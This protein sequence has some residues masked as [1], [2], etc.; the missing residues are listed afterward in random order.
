[1]C[2]MLGWFEAEAALASC[3][4]RRLRS[5][6]A[7]LSGESVLARR[8]GPGE[9]PVPSTPHPCRPRR[10]FRRSDTALEPCRPSR[11]QAIEEYSF[12]AWGSTVMRRPRRPEAGAGGTLADDLADLAHG[13]DLLGQPGVLVPVLPPD[14]AARLVGSLLIGAMAAALSLRV[15]AVFALG[16]RLLAIHVARLLTVGLLLAFTGGAVLPP[17]ALRARL[18]R[19]LPGRGLL[20]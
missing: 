1:M 2:T 10:V 5:G 20:L 17:G 15:L 18:L 9:Y 11:S 4:K 6:S 8:T 3:T 19:L 16:A 7:R 12:G 13:G 14:A